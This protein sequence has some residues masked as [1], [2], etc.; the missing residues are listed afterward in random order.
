MP[1]YLVKR[2]FT[3][4]LHIPMG[5]MGA[6]TSPK[7]PAPTSIRCHLGPLLCNACKDKDLVHSLRGSPQ[8]VRESATE[9]N[10]PVDRITEVRLLDPHFYSSRW[11]ACPGR[12]PADWQ[13]VVT[14][15]RGRQR[16]LPPPGRCR[17]LGLSAAPATDQ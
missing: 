4:G 11:G 3:D 16:T 15:R 1:R 14:Q 8:A 12:R 5:P 17:V 9:N 10:F 7:L 6:K 13:R 2:S